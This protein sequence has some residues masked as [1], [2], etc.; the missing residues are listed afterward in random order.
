MK[1]IYLPGNYTENSF[2]EINKKYIEATYAN[3]M[4]NN[5]R[6]LEFNY[7]YDNDI[8]AEIEFEKNVDKMSMFVGGLIKFYSYFYTL[9]SQKKFLCTIGNSSMELGNIV[10]GKYDFSLNHVVFSGEPQDSVRRSIANLAAMICCQIVLMHEMGHVLNGHTRLLDNLYCSG[11]LD[12]ILRG[13]LANRGVRESAY[14]LDRRTLEMDADAYSITSTFIEI[15]SLFKSEEE[16][17]YLECFQNR[18]GIFEIYGLAMISVFMFL[19]KEY[20][21]EY[22]KNSFY[23]P[24]SCRMGMA[25]S[26]VE[27]IA[28]EMFP[29]ETDL[30]MN[31]IKK[32]IVDGERMFNS[33]N[34]TDIH[35]ISEIVVKERLFIEFSDEVNNCWDKRIKGMLKKYAQI[36]LYGE[37]D[38]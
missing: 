34:Q 29:E 13:V 30:V 12:M 14:A 32:G 4:K 10:F 35:L 8:Q 26:I 21:V 20:S 1:E 11:K 2:L 16:N 15:H 38:D 28:K 9:F 18:E 24:N 3:H 19:E 36:E 17:Y 33:I 7:I 23:L 5:K 37:K 31:E 25:Y 22:S 27:R 6:H